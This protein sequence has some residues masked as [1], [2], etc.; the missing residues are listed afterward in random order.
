MKAAINLLAEAR[1][2]E[3]RLRR[4]GY[5]LQSVS[6][7]TLVGVGVVVFLLLSYTLVL[8]RQQERVRESIRDQ[9]LRIENARGKETKHLLLKQK[10]T[11]AGQAV[12]E[13]S[14]PYIVGLAFFERASEYSMVRGLEST[15]GDSAIHVSGEAVDVFSL[16]GMLDGLADFAREQQ[17][18]RLIGE[19]F[20][21][22]KEGTYDYSLKLEMGGQ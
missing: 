8:G 2:I 16:V 7:A 15:Q 21:R 22:T 18:V 6:V 5:F 1:Q 3:A 13:A 19:G 14:L 12:S 10:L 20:S 4:L 9:E 17:A 11:L